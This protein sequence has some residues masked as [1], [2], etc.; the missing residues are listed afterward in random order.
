MKVIKNLDEWW[1][2][3]EAKRLE[4]YNGDKEWAEHRTYTSQGV[5]IGAVMEFIEMKLY[6]W[7]PEQIKLVE[8]ENTET[9][10]KYW[11]EER[12]EVKYPSWIEPTGRTVIAEV[13]TE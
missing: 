3:L 7:A 13:I 9:G 12:E 1:E 10:E 6:R 4:F 8:K 2:A 5:E 11:K